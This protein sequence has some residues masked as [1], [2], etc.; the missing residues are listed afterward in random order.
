MIRRL[1]EG[2]RCLRRIARLLG[3]AVR[4]S[5]ADNE[6]ASSGIGGRFGPCHSHPGGKKS[7]CA[8]VDPLA[9]ARTAGVPP[10]RI[11]KAILLMRGQKVM[12]NNAGATDL[13]GV[14]RPGCAAVPGAPCAKPLGAWEK[15]RKHSSVMTLGRGLLPCATL[16]LS[17]PPAS[18]YASERRCATRT[19]MHLPP[20]RRSSRSRTSEPLGAGGYL[21]C[22]ERQQIA[23]G[24]LGSL[25]FYRQVADN[26]D[27][28]RN[29]QMEEIGTGGLGDH[30]PQ[31]FLGSG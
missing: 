26:T 17:A 2:A 15:G 29:R 27:E 12:L 24:V 10:D 16:L 22:C 14:G 30:S 6:N 13:L 31:N 9:P 19:P 18:A 5:R 7:N 23:D 20:T 1:H 25:D 28:G 11:E 8:V 3:A 4:S 21:C